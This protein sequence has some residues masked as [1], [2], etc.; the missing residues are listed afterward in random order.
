[1]PLERLTPATWNP[2]IVKTAD[3]E[4]LC[5]SIEADP[6]F[7]WRRPVLAQMDGIIYAG[8]TRFRAVEHLGWKAVPAC[9]EDVPEQLA[10][11]R[12]LRDNNS[13]GSWEDR[14]L[15]DL[16]L[17]ME[18]D[19]SDL[20]LVGWNNDTLD[21][22]LA[23]AVPIAGL[24]DHGADVDAAEELRNEWRT[25]PGQLWEVP[26]K[27]RPKLTHRIMCG[28]ST[29]RSDVDQLLEGQRPDCVITDPPYDLS[30]AT[31]R[32][33]LRLVADRAVVLTSRKQ[34]FTLVG[35]EWR[36]A[37]DFVWHHTFP[38]TWLTKVHPVWYHANVLMMARAGTKMDW[39]HAEGGTPSIFQVEGI[40][41][42]PGTHEHAKGSALFEHMMTGVSAQH[43]ADPFLGTG[44]TL[45]ACENMGRRMSGM[46]LN[47]VYLAMALGRWKSS[48]FAPRMVSEG[49]PDSRRKIA[50]KHEA[51]TTHSSAKTRRH[52][53]SSA[54]ERAA[55][56]ASA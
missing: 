15:G 30:P 7:M 45:I 13:A 52:A 4:A 41:Y 35:E 5:K 18:R 6:D 46:E 43:W 36:Y 25:E 55:R 50:A 2:R 51:R 24:E 22:L 33:A 16:M 47:P 14:L 44:A 48:G 1:V 8:N 38:R 3:F 32:L 39:K 49:L 23:Q 9:V 12:A 29:L 10:K 56:R 11:E 28:D 54:K 26:S 21:D 17:S 31:V 53:A 27:I 37:L 20:S 19:E 34:A 40:E 42:T